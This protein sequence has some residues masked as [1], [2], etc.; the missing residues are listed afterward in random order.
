MKKASTQQVVV[1]KVVQAMMA[2]GA[3][4]RI[5]VPLARITL[6]ASSAKTLSPLASAQ[7]RKRWVVS[8]LARPS[9]I[10]RFMFR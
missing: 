9:A 7:S 1:K 4:D 6:I 5:G 2:I 8:A 3:A 10:R